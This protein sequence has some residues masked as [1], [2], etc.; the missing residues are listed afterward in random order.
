VGP[1]QPGKTGS[2][3]RKGYFYN[4]IGKFFEVRNSRSKGKKWEKAAE[5]FL[6]QRGL[7]T[8]ERNFHCRFGEIDLVMKDGQTL[9]FT[10]VRYRADNR[11]GSG[12]ESVTRSK[13][14]RLIRAA[15]MFLQKH[16]H[17]PEQACR[18]DV[19]SI[20]G[21]SGRPEVDWIKSAF[22]AD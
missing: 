4:R 5:S 18:F 19:I 22:S 21:H 7:K 3:G 12:A 2:D 11:H 6:K 20:R 15:S 10:E 8:L 1:I 16:A 9:V 17:H 14:Q 13:Q